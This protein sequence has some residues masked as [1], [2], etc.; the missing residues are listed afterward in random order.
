MC[1]TAGIYWAKELKSSSSLVRRNNHT[2][3][4]VSQV[5]GIIKKKRSHLTMKTSFVFLKF[6]HRSLE[7]SSFGLKYLT[8]CI[9][10]PNKHRQHN[11][12]SGP[13]KRM[14]VNVPWV[15]NTKTKATATKLFS[16]L[17]ITH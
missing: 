13:R 1:C 3:V 2:E 15:I 12:E 17:S 8:C 16:T 11:E 4:L 6:F 5:L 14:A 10:K 7:F 9:T